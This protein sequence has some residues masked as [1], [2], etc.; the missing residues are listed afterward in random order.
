MDVCC[1]RKRDIQIDNL[2]NGIFSVGIVWPLAFILNNRMIVQPIISILCMTCDFILF[3]LFVGG[4]WL[5][6]LVFLRPRKSLEAP[7][8][9]SFS[10][11]IYGFL[12]PPPPCWLSF[13]I[14]FKSNLNWIIYSKNI[15]RVFFSLLVFAA[16]PVIWIICVRPPLMPDE[17]NSIRSEREKRMYFD[18]NSLS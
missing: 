14:T 10:P 15:V 7:L 18:Y 1:E 16:A 2:P 12:S 11:S 17:I 13:S 5:L 4:C 8:S 3:S 9:F 6:L